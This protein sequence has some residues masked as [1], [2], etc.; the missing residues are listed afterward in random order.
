MLFSPHW[1]NWQIAVGDLFEL[2]RPALFLLAAFLSACVLAAA[3]RRAAPPHIIAL[4]TLGTFFYP[5]IIL[6]LYLATRIFTNLR[7]QTQTTSLPTTETTAQLST[8][9]PTPATSPVPEAAADASEQLPF[10]QTTDAAK[11]PSHQSPARLR[12]A[13]LPALYFVSL[14]ALGLLFFYRDHASVEGHLARASN[15]KLL[16]QRERAIRE[17]RA[18]LRLEDHPHTHKLLALEL[19]DA[20]HHQPALNEFLSAQRGGEPDAT[21]AFRLALTLDALNRSAEAASLYQEFLRS[22]P[23]MRDSRDPLCD[24]AERRLRVADA[25]AATRAGQ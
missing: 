16:G 6:P 17:Y 7:Q 23:C 8:A 4:W 3:R 20:G 12:R 5:H 9:T 21:L 1:Q 19:S 14:L 18:A 11:L 13:L 10:H 25:A 2:L 22:P 24:E 15:A